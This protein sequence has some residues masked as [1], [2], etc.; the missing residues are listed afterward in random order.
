M[1]IKL[2]RLIIS[3]IVVVL[4]YG[5]HT[6]FA[7]QSS[8][9]IEIKMVNH[10]SLKT[11]IKNLA[12]EIEKTAELYQTSNQRAYWEIEGKKSFTSLLRSE[13]YYSSTIDVEL[14]SQDQDIII[15]NIEPWQRYKLANIN[16]QHSKGP[17]KTIG[18]PS[19][20]PD[21]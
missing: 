1:H 16:I 8:L 6:I 5:V 20:P 13:G 7:S 10:S 17:R 15:F 3:T 12:R 19:C 18:Q 14:P 11:K 9:K 2:V 21:I 4:I